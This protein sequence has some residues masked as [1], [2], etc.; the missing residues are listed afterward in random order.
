M[1]SMSVGSDNGCPSSRVSTE[2]KQHQPQGLLCWDQYT[3]A[4]FAAVCGRPGALQSMGAVGSAAGN[5]AAESFNAS[6]KREA[7]EGKG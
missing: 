6:L 5:A 3:S 4:V 1:L 2:L 7:L